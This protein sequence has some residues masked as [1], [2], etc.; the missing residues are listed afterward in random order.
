MIGVTERFSNQVLTGLLCVYF[1]QH[2]EK[3]LKI[4]GDSLIVNITAGYDFIGL[5]D[6]KS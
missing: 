6:K 5:Y 3:I 1:P 4:Q 2:K